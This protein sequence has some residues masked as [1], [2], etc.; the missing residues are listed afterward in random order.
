MPTRCT[1]DAWAPRS[2][3]AWALA[4]PPSPTHGLHHELNEG[5]PSSHPHHELDEVV[6][7]AVGA[8]VEDGAGLVEVDEGALGV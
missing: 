3:C 6:R 8:D 7:R 4:S 5:A 1:G 2:V